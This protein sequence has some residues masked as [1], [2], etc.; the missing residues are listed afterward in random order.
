MAP[1]ILANPIDSHL[2]NGPRT[3]PAHSGRRCQPP[4]KPAQGVETLFALMHAKYDIALLV[5]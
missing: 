2:S 1:L 4:G 5:C 3:G